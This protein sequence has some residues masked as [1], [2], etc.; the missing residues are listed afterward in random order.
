[1]LEVALSTARPEIVIRYRDQLRTNMEQ[2]QQQIVDA[3][4]AARLDAATREQTLTK[5]T[6]NQRTVNAKIAE[7]ETLIADLTAVRHAG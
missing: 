5:L 3:K 7:I 4:E 1:M 2:V 6:G